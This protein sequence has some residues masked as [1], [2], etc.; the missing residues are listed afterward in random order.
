M[1]VEQ[2]ALEPKQ[3]G[4]VVAYLSMEIA[5]AEDVP[6]YSGGLGVLAGDHLRAAADAGVPLVGVSLLY[7]RGY[8]AQEILEEE[9]QRERPVHWSPAGLLERVDLEVSVPVGGRFI[10][11]GAWRAE[12]TGRR[13]SVP[14]YFLDARVPGNLPEDQEVTDVLYGGDLRM[15]LRQE[16]VLGLGGLAL[17]RALGCPVV[18]VHLNEGHAAFA[19]LG[20]L[21]EAAGDWEAVQRRCVFTTHTPVAAGHDRFPEALVRAEL[22]EER[23]AALTARGLL[24]PG[25]ELNMTELA[26]AGSRWCNAVSRRHAQVAGQMFPQVGF[27]AITNGVHA[28]TWV[29]P[30]IARVLDRRIPRWRDDQAE[31]AAAERT[32]PLDELA[33]ARREAKAA[34]VELVAARCG[35]RLDPAA[36]TLGIA[37]RV[38]AYKRTTLA[39]AHPD[40]LRSISRE[41]GPLQLV[42][43]GKAH[44][45]D[46]PGKALIREVLAARRSLAPDVTVVFLPDYD[47]RGARILVAGVDVWCNTPVR[48]YEASGTS[49]MKAA[50]NAVPSLS[51]LDGWW[52][53]GH[54]EGIT[55]WAVGG[56]PEHVG[57]PAGRPGLDPTWEEDA[58]SFAEV[59]A[60]TVAPLYYR[61]PERFL[62]VGRGALA[63]NGSRFT[64][65]RMLAEYLELAYAPGW[66]SGVDWTAGSIDPVA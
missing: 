39:L 60:G 8:F 10:R 66:L 17:L 45:Q 49:G 36:L 24:P 22:G 6:T 58:K 16:L 1:D 5:V 19:L 50:L 18:T 38:T 43:A 63:R 52:V 31:L 48:P 64:T 55:G 15:R 41:I 23:T 65:Q 26:L 9:G 12:V 59:L 40:R 20:L 56:P 30:S 35:V 2:G 11:L 33:A 62:A 13:S 14:V 32:V 7:H 28:P 53:E 29:G 61:E 54:E 21:E 4:G 25:G 51:V 3:S 57:D 44:P 42:F 37:R 46:E 27:A 34:L 47:L